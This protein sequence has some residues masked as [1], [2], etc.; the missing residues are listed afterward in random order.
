MDPRVTTRDHLMALARLGFNR[1]SMGVQDFDP[2]VQTAINRVQP[3]EATRELVEQARSLGFPSVNMDLIFGL[4][5]Q[6]AESFGE[7]DRPGPRR[8]A[9]IGSPSTRTPTCRG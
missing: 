2:R 8:S 4:P 9:R 5:F 7:D 1:L 6:T 3:Y